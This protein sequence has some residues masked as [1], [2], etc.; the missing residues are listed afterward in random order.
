MRIAIESYGCSANMNDAEIMKGML[1]D[2]HTISDNANLVI[3]NSCTVKGPTEKKILKSIKSHLDNDKRVIVTGCMAESQHEML[4]S[5][6]PQI[7]IIGPDHIDSIDEHLYKSNNTVIIGKR[8]LD[9]PSLK[10]KS[11]NVVSGIIQIS[12]GCDS[13]CSYCITKAAKGHILSYPMQSI[14]ERAGMLIDEG[15]KEL[16]I[17]SQDNTAYGID[18]YSMPMLPN[19]LKR[20]LRIEG[21]FMIRNGMGNPHNLLFCID[22]LIDVYKHPKMYKFLHIPLQSGSQKIIDNMRRRHTIEDHKYIISRFRNAIPNITIA[23]DIIYGYPGET[24]DDFM[25]TLSILE[26]MNFDIVNISR[27]W[28]RPGTSASR[29]D[30]LPSHILSDRGSKITRLF[31]KLSLK[32]NSAWIGWRGPILLCEKGKHN[33]MVGRNEYYKHIV[34]SSEEI[35]RNNNEIFIGDKVMVEIIGCD[36]FHLKA[37]I[38]G[39]YN[40]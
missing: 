24:D 5:W 23:T 40:D 7:S 33:S 26:E 29:L 19:L 10:Q 15:K 6:F 4:L 31:R 34:L 13:A 37:K 32:K 36:T 18:S 16:W 35:T 30:M 2:E 9:K 22:S 3:V 1:E 25:M 11:G 14:V 8:F 38:I 21:D 17:A 12:R 27:F 39:G 20:I 28:P